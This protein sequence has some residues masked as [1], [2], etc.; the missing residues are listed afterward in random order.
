MLAPGRH[1]FSLIVQQC[2]PREQGATRPIDKAG[3]LES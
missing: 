1:Q 2:P 3:E